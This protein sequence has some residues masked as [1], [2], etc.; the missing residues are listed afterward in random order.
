MSKS[1]KPNLYNFRKDQIC[2][3]FYFPK[4]EINYLEI[5]AQIIQWRKHFQVDWHFE[6]FVF[7]LIEMILLSEISK[8]A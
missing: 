6:L 1:K 5:D 4:N 7:H 3:K 2:S 8:E